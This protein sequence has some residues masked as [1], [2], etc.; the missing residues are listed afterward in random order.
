MIESEKLR[1]FLKLYVIPDSAVGAPRSLLEQTRL[2]LAGG[3]RMIQLREKH[4][5]SL[6]MFRDAKELLRLCH[7][8]GALLIVNDRL[9][10]A[11]A[12]GA[13]GVHLGQEDLPPVMARRLAPQMI[14]GATAHTP[15]EARQAVADGADYL[16][17]GA[18]FPTGSKSNIH[19]IGLPGLKAVCDA[20]RLPIVGIGGITATTASQVIA[21][22]A[23]GCAVIAGVVARA[24]PESAAREILSAMG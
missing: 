5:S 23:D 22:G 11:M 1:Q 8:N 2:A 3:A 16:G 17:V 7:D 18:V 21:A 6:D 20:V 9:D 15:A 4:T 10:I 12:V 14:I 24:D 13:D 19:L